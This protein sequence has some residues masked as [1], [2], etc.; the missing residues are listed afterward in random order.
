MPNLISFVKFSSTTNLRLQLH[1]IIFYPMSSKL[2]HIL[3]LR[4][5]PTFGQPSESVPSVRFTHETLQLEGW[6]LDALEEAAHQTDLTVQRWLPGSFQ[7][8]V[9]PLMARFPHKYTIA[10]GGFWIGSGMGSHSMGKARGPISRG[11]WKSH[12][13]Q[14]NSIAKQKLMTDPWDEWY[15]MVY[16]YTYIYRSMNG[17]FW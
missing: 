9:T 12:W 4:D 2:Y 11:P 13:L 3:V 8:R 7:G 10:A 15:I 14:E 5:A 6:T 1:F 17:W 16:I